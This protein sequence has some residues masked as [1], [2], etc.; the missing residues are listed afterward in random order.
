MTSKSAWAPTIGH[1][2]AKPALR[3]PAQSHRDTLAA[4]ARSRGNRRSLYGLAMKLR[5]HASVVAVG[6]VC[7]ASRGASAAPPWVDRPLTT[8]RGDWA[9]DLGL[10]LGH[11]PAPV[12]DVGAGVNAEM[13]VGL[14]DRVELGL[15]GGV[16]FGDDYERA[17]GGDFYGRLFDRQTFEG[18]A[19]VLSNPEFRVRG[20]LVRARVF[21]L[22][23]EGRLVIP[24]AAG[25]NAG[26]LFGVP[27]A[28]HLGERVR[29]D[30][31]V[32]V[33]VVFVP[34]DAAVGI[35]APLDVWIQITQRLWLGPMTGVA[36][37]RV[38]D[39][40]GATHVSLGFG[41]G[42]SITRYLDFKTMLLFPTI[43]D[44]SGIFGA[45]AGIEA[46]IE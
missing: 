43:H 12:D 41:L 17:I 27:M 24:F 19:E 20:A 11:V 16:R 14:T 5:K 34:N 40:R 8:P 38:G 28:F 36:F 9:F 25:T 37:D 29:L 21:E 32:Y 3:R 15:R 33:P 13:A 45:G 31:G 10:G 7:A 1:T 2:A 22:A 44:Q 30:V 18:G 35:S 23:L 39:P 46:R 4:E 26:A 6:L 42:Y